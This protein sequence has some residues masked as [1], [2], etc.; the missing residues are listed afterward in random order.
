MAGQTYTATMISR[1]ALLP[2]LLAVFTSL[3]GPAEVRAQDSDRF[4]IAGYGTLAATYTSLEE[5]D[6]RTRIEQREGVGATES[7]SLGTDSVLA[8]QL[9]ATLTEEVTATAQVVS[10]RVE[11]DDY[12]PEAEWA[13]LKYWSDDNWYARAGRFVAPAFYNSNVRN[14]GYAQTWLRPPVDVYLLNPLTWMEG[15]DIGT[16][17]KAGDATIRAA[18]AYGTAD[19]RIFVSET[20]VSELGY[21]NWIAHASLETGY[22]RFRAMVW[23]IRGR[24]GNVPDNQILSLFETSIDSLVAAGLPGA[25]KLRGEIQ[26]TQPIQAYFYNLAYGYTH[27]VWVVE[28]EIVQRWVSGSAIQDAIGGYVMVGRRFGTITPYL[29]YSEVRSG[30]DMELPRIDATGQPPPLPFYALVA[31]TIA[32]VMTTNR[33]S[34]TIAAGARLDAMENLA[35][36]GQWDHIRKP[37][38]S[39]GDMF[40]NADPAWGANDQSINVFTLALDFVF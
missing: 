11:F 20:S 23:D 6:Y 13:Y 19:T 24:I 37:D 34:H 10:R 5:A 38:G 16:V 26:Y 30:E 31:N 21:R 4:R 14:I 18:L 3:T 2:S 40:V 25:G 33:S 8:V 1:R 32:D 7:S 17:F 9:D 27:P 12:E 29:M 36:K 35:I 15:G 39:A 28:S 22:H